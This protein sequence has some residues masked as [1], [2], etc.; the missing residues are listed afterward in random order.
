L[1]RRFSA[2]LFLGRL[3]TGK[4]KN[5]E[6]GNDTGDETFIIHAERM[7]KPETGG[8]QFLRRVNAGFAANADRQRRSFSAF[9]IS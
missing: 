6:Y 1:G 5:G 3:A 2:A 7:R 9:S 4:Q 8:K